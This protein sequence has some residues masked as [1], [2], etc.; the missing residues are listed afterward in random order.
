[1]VVNSDRLDPL[2]GCLILGGKGSGRSTMLKLLLLNLADGIKTGEVSR[3]I[4]HDTDGSLA[5]L[6]KHDP[7]YLNLSPREVGWD[8]AADMWKGRGTEL[9]AAIAQALLSSS[10]DLFTRWAVALF[11]FILESL[12]SERGWS[13]HDALLSVRTVKDRLQGGSDLLALY[14]V[15]EYRDRLEGMIELLLKESARWEGCRRTISIE[16]LLRDKKILLFSCQSEGDK[17]LFTAFLAAFTHRMLNGARVGGQTCIVIDDLD[18]ALFEYQSLAHL[19]LHSRDVNVSL[20]LSFGLEGLARHAGLEARVIAGSPVK[21]ILL[22]HE[23]AKA[24]AAL[25]G[26]KVSAEELLLLPEIEEELQGFEE[27]ESGFVRFRLSRQDVAVL[28]RR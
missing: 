4:A 8:I 19:A 20:A 5:L 13:L 25:V 24:T 7:N 27:V 18:G 17:R 22:R 2:H 16:E 21:R 15:K 3:V 12:S 28:E 1:M 10:P 6:L 26:D 11:A 14:D 9:S 23:E